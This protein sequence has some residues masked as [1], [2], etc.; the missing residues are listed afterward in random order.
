MERAQRFV[1]ALAKL[2]ERGE[3]ESLVSLFGED[4]QV[5]N[6]AS[7]RVFS[8]LE[9]VRQFWRDYKG[10][11]AQVRSTFRNMIESGDRVALE[12]ETQGTAHNGAAVSYEG[13]SIIEWDGDRIL[14]FYAYFD[15]GLLGREMAHGTAERSEVPAT[16]PA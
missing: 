13:V 6:V 12:W 7:R 5:S 1:D 8:G 11:L 14:R 3:V 10:T 9:E 4:A 2:E 16:T 15:P